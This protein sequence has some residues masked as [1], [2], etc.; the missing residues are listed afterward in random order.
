M[1]LYSR[2]TIDDG[3]EGWVESTKLM[4][5]K[6]AREQMIAINKK[7]DTNKEK[8]KE[9]RAIITDLK[10]ANKIL[11]SDLANMTNDKHGLQ[12]T[13]DELKTSA[14]KPIAIYEKNKQLENDITQLS[15]ENKTLISEKMRHL[16]IAV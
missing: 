8:I 6:S 15:E 2:V 13:L 7:L 11:E 10:S 3:K 16:M 9:L 12:K 5:E 14:A 4:N 1:A